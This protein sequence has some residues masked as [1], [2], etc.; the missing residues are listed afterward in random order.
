MKIKKFIS[1][2]FAECLL[3]PAF[4]A[5]AA[6]AIDAKLVT[7]G[8]VYEVFK[9]GNMVATGNLGSVAEAWS[10]AKEF[11]ANND[12]VVVVL[13]S[14]WEEDELLTI[15]E[16]QHIT[17]DLNGHYILRKRNHEMVR[18]GEVFLVEGKAVFTLRDSNPKSKG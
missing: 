6:E 14:D 7:S 4:A 16:N 8:A 15:K 3:L 17:L 1:V 12:E 9:N 10:R 18:N 13:G 5:S 2:F 11:A